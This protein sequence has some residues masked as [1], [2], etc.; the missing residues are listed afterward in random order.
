[1]ATIEVRSWD[2]ERGGFSGW[3]AHA[4]SELKR[5]LNR[6]I[7]GSPQLKR[8]ILRAIKNQN[9]VVMEGV[10]DRYIEQLRHILET[11]GGEVHVIGLQP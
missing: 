8:Q 4:I 1:L 9:P 11:L 7:A 6:A 3:D 10:N 2:P 5:R